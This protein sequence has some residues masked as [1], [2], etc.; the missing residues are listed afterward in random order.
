MTR[1]R[2]LIPILCFLLPGVAAAQTATDSLA[3]A[4]SDAAAATTVAINSV[5][6]LLAGFLVMCLP[7]AFRLAGTGLTRP[8]NP[9]RTLPQY[10]SCCPSCCS[11]CAHEPRSV[12]R[13][14]FANTPT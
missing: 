8:T 14:Y 10:L 7:A 6:T 4:A 2:L 9:V 3:K 1:L 11:A 5:W 13:R 12:G